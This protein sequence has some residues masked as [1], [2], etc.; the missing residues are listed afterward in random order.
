V[1]DIHED[2]VDQLVEEL[3]QYMMGEDPKGFNMMNACS[4]IVCLSLWDTTEVL[5]G[6]ESDDPALEGRLAIPESNPEYTKYWDHLANLQSEVL[7]KAV[8]NLHPRRV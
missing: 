7:M 4:T 3:V 8:L 5:I 6:A 2:D 1:K